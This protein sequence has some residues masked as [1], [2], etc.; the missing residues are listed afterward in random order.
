MNPP[1]EKQIWDEVFD[2][3][4]RTALEQTQAYRSSHQPVDT[5]TTKPKPTALYLEPSLNANTGH[6]LTLAGCYKQLLTNL[7]YQ[8][9]I[10]HALKNS[11]QQQPDHLPYFLVKHHTMASRNIDSSAEMARVEHYFR[12]EF[13]QIIREYT[14]DL[15]VFATIRFTNIVAATQAI[16][17]QNIAHS[18]FG[19]MEAA[20]VP[21]CTDPGIIQTAFSRAADILQKQN[22]SHLLIAETEYIKTYLLNCGFQEENV[23]VFPYVASRQITDIPQ[24]H[25]KDQK[26]IQVGYIGDSRPVRY[27]ELIADLLVLEP[28]PGLVDLNIQLNLAYI[29]NKRNQKLCDE[30]S[31]LHKNGFIKLH[32]PNLSNQ[33]YRELFCSLDFVILPYGERYEQIGSGV[34]FEAIYAGV[35]PIL[36]ADSKLNRF[37]AALGGDAPV[38]ETLSAQAIRAAI[39][40]GVLQYSTLNKMA[41]AIQSKWPDHPSST[42]QWQSKLTNWLPSHIV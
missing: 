21:D 14:P 37:Y 16:T 28:I 39:I 12:N 6:Q 1:T 10:A 41:M 33:Q 8:T 5:P 35:I 2:G 32:P 31:N 22:A 9:I 18:I 40:D 13:E 23:E 38:F 27:P 11:L 17:D 4:V 25:K 7:G 34:L 26:N 30:I 3:S 36:P 19:I 24:P 42:E 20:E 29:K 15:C